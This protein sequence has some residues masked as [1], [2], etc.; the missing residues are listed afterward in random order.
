[1]TKKIWKVTAVLLILMLVGTLLPLQASA[2]NASTSKNPKIVF[3]G[4][5]VMYGRNGAKKT[6]GKRELIP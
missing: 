2:A 5:S 6:D 4:D 3:F 1:M